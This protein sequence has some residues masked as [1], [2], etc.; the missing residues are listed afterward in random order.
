MRLDTRG[1]SPLSISG[2]TGCWINPGYIEAG[3]A[4]SERQ[5]VKA[6]RGEDMS[7]VLYVRIIQEVLLPPD[8][9]VAAH[10]G[11]SREWYA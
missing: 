7:Q 11:G 3:R 9:L 5:K 8:P 6:A 4:K 10:G 1:N 2:D